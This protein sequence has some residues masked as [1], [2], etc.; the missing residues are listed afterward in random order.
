MEP[1]TRTE[2]NI[3]SERK[4]LKCII[5]KVQSVIKNY[6]T[7]EA[8]GNCTQSKEKEQLIEAYK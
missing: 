3:L 4:S 1:P 6:C 7:C 2:F 8:K 5:Y